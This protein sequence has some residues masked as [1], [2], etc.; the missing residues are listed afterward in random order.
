EFQYRSR[1]A[2]SWWKHLKEKHSTTPS[3]AGCLLRCDCGHESYSHMHGQECQTANFTIIRNEDAPIR[4]IEMTP[5]CV[6]CKIHPKTPGGYIM[7]LRR[8][9]KTTLKGNG[10]YLKCSCGARY[11]HEKDY[12]KHDKKCTGTDYTLHK[13]DEN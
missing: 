10:V 7:H 11:N 8:H 9:H 12:L 13:L 5:Q 1:S 2:I 4:R 6:L 3:L